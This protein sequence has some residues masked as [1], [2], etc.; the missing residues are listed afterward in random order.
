M[1]LSLKILEAGF[2]NLGDNDLSSR[3]YIL[4]ILNLGSVKISLNFYV[5]VFFS[6]YLEA[7]KLLN[8]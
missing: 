1:L 8:R 4:L 7:K 5:P 3:L 2:C 6:Y